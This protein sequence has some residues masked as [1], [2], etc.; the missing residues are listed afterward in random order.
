VTDTVN[1]C[2]LCFDARHQNMLPL[3]VHI[4]SNHDARIRTHAFHESPVRIGRSPFAGLRLRDP[5]VS[6]WQAVVRFHAERTTYLDLGSKNPTRIDGRAME[7]NVEVEID[8]KSLVCIGALRLRFQRIA[9]EPE[10]CDPASDEPTVFLP[11][12]FVEPERPSGTLRLPSPLPHGA[13][14][15][16]TVRMPAQPPPAPRSGNH[17]EPLIAAHRAYRRACS[18]FLSLVR[19][20]VESIPSNSRASRV[21][22]L[23]RRFPE[24]I[25]E[26]SFRDCVQGAGV[27]PAQLGHLDVQDWL[28]RLCGTPSTLSV[29]QSALSMECVGHLLEMFA[30]AF[31]ESRR[32][33]QRARRRLALA[34]LARHTTPLQHSEDP[35]AVLSYLLDPD[36]DVR[37]RSAELRRTLA[38]FAMHQIALLSAVVEGA[39]S[40]LDRLGPDTLHQLDDCMHGAPVLEHEGMWSRIWPYRARKL[41]NRFLV[42][43]H[44]LTQADHFTRELFGRAFAR[45]YHAIAD[46]ATAVGPS[47]PNAQRGDAPP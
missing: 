16:Q 23:A 12:Q 27:H 28:G 4:A 46:N 10:P 43:H 18:E 14:E 11:H 13:P 19:G 42:R 32:A 30:A 45:R 38:D 25:R 44:D 34:P 26:P 8:D 7:R 33:H 6:E 3:V 20:H 36:S 24:L 15:R 35:H 21:L 41:W 22:A 29:E 9:H 1:A 17:D 40:M 37:E 39:R 5:F 47:A 2:V 31:I